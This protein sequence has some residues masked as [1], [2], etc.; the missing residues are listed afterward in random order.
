MR[1]LPEKFMFQAAFCITT[2]CT[3]QKTVLK[4]HFLND[5]DVI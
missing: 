5:T 1:K 3:L 2:S 4:S